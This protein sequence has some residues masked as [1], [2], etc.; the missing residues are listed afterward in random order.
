MSELI[1]NIQKAIE[2]VSYSRHEVPNMILRILKED[3]WRIRK[4]KS[5]LLETREYNFFPD[6]IEAPRPWGLQSEWKFINDLCKGYEEVELE[7][8]KALTGE[9]G[10]SHQSMTDHHTSIKKTGK[11]RQLMRLEKERPDLLHKIEM[12]ELSVNAAIIE[13][14]F[15]KPRIKAT[16]QPKSVVKMIKTHFQQD[17]ISE[18]IKLLSELE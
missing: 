6:F 5:G 15:V 3:K 13:A 2:Y 12:K 9:S 7:L 16:K 1:E 8:A 14:G 17:E 18:I 11:Q 10:K 4:P